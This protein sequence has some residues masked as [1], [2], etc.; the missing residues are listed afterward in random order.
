ME[1][2]QPNDLWTRRNLLKTG[3]A[4]AVIAVVPF[5][6]LESAGTDGGRRGTRG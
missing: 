4:A 2:R 6:R 5:G 1:T 3:A